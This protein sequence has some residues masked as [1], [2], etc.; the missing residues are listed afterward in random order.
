MCAAG[1]A[2]GRPARLGTPG[3]EGTPGSPGRPGTAPGKMGY[4]SPKWVCVWVWTCLRGGGDL[5][6]PPAPVLTADDVEDPEV[7]AE[8]EGDGG[9]DPLRPLLKPPPGE[10]VAGGRLMDDD[11]DDEVTVVEVDKEADDECGDGDG[12]VALPPLG[13]RTALSCSSWILWL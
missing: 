5:L 8:I 3:R 7:A 11:D 10:D 4:P 1:G 6:A 2:P 13:D 12:V 9:D